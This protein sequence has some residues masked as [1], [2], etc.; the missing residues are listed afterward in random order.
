MK[1]AQI[2][3]ILLCLENHSKG[4]EEIHAATGRGA[5]QLS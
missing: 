3:S 2:F 1:Q 5:E 4:V